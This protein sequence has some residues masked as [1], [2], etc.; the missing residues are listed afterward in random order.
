[1]HIT[2]NYACDQNYREKQKLYVASQHAS[3]KYEETE[4]VTPQYECNW[5]HREQKLSSH[6]VLK[7]PQEAKKHLITNTSFCISH[8][9]QV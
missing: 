3:D 5:A 9:L 2:S 4:I 7:Q 6:H 1:M 8:I